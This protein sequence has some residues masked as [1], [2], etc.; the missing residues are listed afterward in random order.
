LLFKRL[1]RNKN[2]FYSAK[3]FI[4]ITAKRNSATNI[5]RARNNSPSSEVSSRDFTTSRGFNFTWKLTE[6]GFLNLT[7]SYALNISSSLAYLETYTVILL[8]HHDLKVIYGMIYL[9]VQ[10]LAEIIA[11]SKILISELHQNFHHF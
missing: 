9:M 6:G 3:F 1:Q 10:D 4:V 7:T 2:L 11:T 8:Q 5:T